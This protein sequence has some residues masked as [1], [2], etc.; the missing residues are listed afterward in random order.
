MEQMTYT[1][2][3]QKTYI[4][5]L[6]EG[7]NP[8]KQIYFEQHNKKKPLVE[9]KTLNKH[10]TLYSY[11]K[12]ILFYSICLLFCM[13]IVFCTSEI[14]KE[15]FVEQMVSAEDQYYNQLD[16][17]FLQEIKLKLQENGYVN[18]GVTLTKV[19]EEEK[20]IIYQIRIYNK[21]LN[22]LSTEEQSSLKEDINS[23][24]AEY[25]DCNFKIW[26]QYEQEN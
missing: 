6:W 1:M 23:I 17:I 22:N 14:V 24:V 7:S 26:L 25:E 15:L 16:G 11:T 3:N 19:I 10:F 8:I 18:T 5:Q 12:E 4:K 13:L 2:K 9:Q 20:E 21:K